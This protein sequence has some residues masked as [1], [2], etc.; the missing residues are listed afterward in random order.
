M[1]LIFL[2]SFKNI[3]ILKEQNNLKNWK[4]PRYI[5]LRIEY[6]HQQSKSWEK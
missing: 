6:T 5:C 1:H 4:D 3:E 2:Y